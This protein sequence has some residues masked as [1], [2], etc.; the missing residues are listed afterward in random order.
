MIKY[1]IQ[2]SALIAGVCLFLAMYAIFICAPEEAT[3]GI[4][5]KIFYIHV[6]LAWWGFISFFLVFLSSIC[7]LTTKSIRWHAIALANAEVGVVFT[8]LVLST[9]MIWGRTS[10]GVWWTWDPKL[11]TALLLFF[12][13]MGYLII[14]GMDIEESKRRMFSA[15]LGIVAFLDVPLVFFAARLWRSIHPTVFTSQGAGITPAMLQIFLFTLGSM[16]FLWFA[17]VFYRYCQV[18]VEYAIHI[19]LASQIGE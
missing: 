9:G 2:F 14:Q 16:F 15:V 17:L 19:K 8:I 13:Y 11:T 12:I 6:P 18:Q 3:L 10:W 7:Y 5:Q 4:I 1:L